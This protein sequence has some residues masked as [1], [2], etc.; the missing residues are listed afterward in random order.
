MDDSVNKH[1][2]NGDVI[3]IWP[4]VILAGMMSNHGGAIRMYFLARSLDPDGKGWIKVSIL[5]D[6]LHSLGVKE[7]K[8]R[9][10]LSD[11]LSLGLMSED[12]N[13]GYRLCSLARGALAIN[14]DQVGRPAEVGSRN[15]IKMGWQSIVWGAFLSTLDNRLVSQA[16][17]EELTGVPQRTQRFYQSKLCVKTHKNYVRTDL[18]A[19]CLPGMQEFV[20]PSAFTGKD[21][22]IYFR[23]PDQVTIPGYVAIPGLKGRSRK[24]Q[25]QVNASCKEARR[26]GSLSSAHLFYYTMKNAEKA[27]RK[28]G[29]SISPSELPSEIFTLTHEGKRINLWSP[30]AVGKVTA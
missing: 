15:L 13:Q 25:K 6:L 10:W 8:R 2:F 16:M 22:M 26:N 27:L 24:A 5:R 1:Q 23:L 7:R 4:N 21:G 12:H 3:K 17:K 29:R 28:L 30:T 19:D 11:A 18:K 14:C 20:K 9:R